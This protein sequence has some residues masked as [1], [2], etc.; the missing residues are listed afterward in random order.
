[1]G[2]GPSWLV[3]HAVADITPDL[4][5]GPVYLAGYGV[6]PADGVRDPLAAHAVALRYGS[7]GVVIVSLDLL[8]LFHEDCASLQGAT[9]NALGHAAPPVVVTCTHTHAGPDLL[10]LWGPDARTR[11]V[12]DPCRE[13]VITAASDAAARAWQRARPAHLLVAAGRVEG[14]AHNS[15]DPGMLDPVLTLL[16]WA[17]TASPHVPVLQVLHFACHPEALG[18]ADRRVSADLAGE[19]RRR[20]A[21]E[22]GCPCVFWQGALGGMVGPDARPGEEGEAALVRLGAA[23]GAAAGSLV[24]ALRPDAGGLAL[25]RRSVALPQTNPHFAAGRAAGIIHRPVLDGTGEPPMVA[26]SAGLLRLGPYLFHLAPGEVLPAVARAWDHGSRAALP[27][28][29][30]R[31]LGLCDDEVGYILQ[32]EDFT[33]G[34]YEESVS[35]GPRTAALLGAAYAEL[36]ATV[37]G[38]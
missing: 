34:R 35:L 32:E 31:V 12:D 11:G 10:G 16:S 24:P 36:R 3:G 6:R 8:G 28:L 29:E 18:P 23:L 26:S 1:M 21:A 20:V 2:L 7:V 15:R 37:S 30:P 19:S 25:A 13:R 17:T 5:A 27:G 22:S 9:R 4:T 14:V 33:P 38:P